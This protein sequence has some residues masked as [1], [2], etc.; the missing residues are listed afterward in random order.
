MTKVI[1]RLCRKQYA[2]KGYSTTTHL[3]LS[4]VAFVTVEIKMI[5]NNIKNSLKTLSY[6]FDFYVGEKYLECLMV[7]FS[8]YNR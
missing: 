4:D 2:N 3:V 5:T 6:Q 1:C 8:D 7:K